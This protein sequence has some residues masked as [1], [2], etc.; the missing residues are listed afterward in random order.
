MT[1]KTRSSA[2]SMQER[3]RLDGTLAGQALDSRSAVPTLMD[4][5]SVSEKKD[6][7]YYIP[8]WWT[9]PTSEWLIAVAAVPDPTVVPDTTT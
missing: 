8:F 5:R 9:E 1:A 2:D 6:V 7:M 3:A 4:S